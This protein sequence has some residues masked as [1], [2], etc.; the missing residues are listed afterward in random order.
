M[1]NGDREA[2][3]GVVRAINDAWL[4][5]RAEEM[6]DLLHEDVVM[7]QPG[8]ES[9]LRGR[10]ECI[11]S[12]GEFASSARIDDFSG[13]E[14]VVDIWEDTAVAWFS[15]RIRYEMGGETFSE[16]GHDVYVLGRGPHGWVV[17]WRTL[18]ARPVGPDDD[19]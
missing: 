4:G 9:A 3:A 1:P 6:R 8:F 5:D 18:T 12:F 17:V 19:A 7:V 10:D 13:S 16:L 14:P 11:A 2:V 15:W